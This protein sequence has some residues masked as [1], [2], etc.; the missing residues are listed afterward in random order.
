MYAASAQPTHST[1]IR[2]LDAVLFLLLLYQSTPG[3]GLGQYFSRPGS[4]YRYHPANT[5]RSGRHHDTTAAAVL[6]RKNPFFHPVQTDWRC[7]DSGPPE[8]K[9]IY[10][11]SP[12]P[13]L[14]TDAAPRT[15]S[16]LGGARHSCPGAI[17]LAEIRDLVPG[18][19]VGKWS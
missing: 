14:P 16:V 13:D 2:L 9:I 11:T 5:F 12:G 4:C 8:T 6:S 7:T 19:S 15:H 3:R 1:V 18:S 17:N 10:S